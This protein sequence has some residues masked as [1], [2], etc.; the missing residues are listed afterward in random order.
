MVLGA[1]FEFDKRHNNEIV[2]RPSDNEDIPRVSKLS[3][4]NSKCELSRNNTLLLNCHNHAYTEYN[5]YC[6]QQS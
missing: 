6:H 3:E 5:H 2:S 1:S 4:A